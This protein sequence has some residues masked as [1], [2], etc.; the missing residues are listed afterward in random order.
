MRERERRGNMFLVCVHV[1]SMVCVFRGVFGRCNETATLCF[2]SACKRAPVEV[3]DL[4][5][6]HNVSCNYPDAFGV[7]V[8]YAAFML[9]FEKQCPCPT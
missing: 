3:D 6:I 4:E 5:S 1:F 8:G 7:A 9:G 2:V